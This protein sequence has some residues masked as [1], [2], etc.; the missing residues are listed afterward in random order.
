M[1][2]NGFFIASYISNNIKYWKKKWRSEKLRMQHSNLTLEEK[3][4]STN[5]QGFSK[6]IQTLIVAAHPCLLRLFSS[7][8]DSKAK[9]NSL[10]W[11][12]RRRKEP[13]PFFL[14]FIKSAF[15]VAIKM[16]L[17]ELS[18]LGRQ[19]WALAKKRVYCWCWNLKN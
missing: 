10:L 1:K 2:I 19:G 4:F 7:D 5:F 18:N 12:Q 8:E 3:S 9:S 15:I 6:R 13:S 14:N 17:F 16:F 11:S